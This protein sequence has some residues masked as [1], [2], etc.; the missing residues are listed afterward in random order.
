MSAQEY[1]GLTS[2]SFKKRYANHKASFM[3]RN[4]SCETTLSRHIWELKDKGVP[5]KTTWSIMANAPSYSKQTRLCQLCLM[6]KTFIC[7]TDQK[8]ILNK[9]SEIISKCRHRDKLLLKHW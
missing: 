8:K 7:T 5:F 2:T 1:I 6:E 3:H 9:R 4:K